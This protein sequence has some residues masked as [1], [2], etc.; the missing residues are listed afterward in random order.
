MQATGEVTDEVT[1]EVGRLLP[2]LDGEIS[3]N[4]PQQALK[5]C[6]LKI[7]DGI[8]DGISDF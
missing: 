3:K 7:F 5:L 8:S 2:D 4:E 6:R 1:G